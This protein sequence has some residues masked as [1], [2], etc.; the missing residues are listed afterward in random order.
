MRWQYYVLEV[1]NQ[2]LSS[3]LEA[4]MDGLGADGWELVHV[5]FGLEDGPSSWKQ[6]LF[7]KRR[8]EGPPPR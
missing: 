3:D 7:F 4:K 8:V 6:R 2:I 5:L 1:P